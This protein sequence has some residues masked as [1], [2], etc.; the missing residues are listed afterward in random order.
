MMFPI[1]NISSTVASNITTTI[2]STMDIIFSLLLLIVMPTI[3]TRIKR[4][5]FSIS[6]QGNKP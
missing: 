5:P 2:L 1:V 6:T 3:S 4:H